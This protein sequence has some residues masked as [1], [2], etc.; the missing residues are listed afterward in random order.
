MLLRDIAYALRTL[1]KAPIFA[2]TAILTIALGI[3]ASTAIF[4]VTHA[5][6]L[7]PLPYSNPDRLVF[8]ISDLRNRNVKDSLFPT[9]ISWIFATDRRMCFRT[10]R[11][12]RPSAWS[13]PSKMAR[14]NWSAARR[15]A[16]TS[17][18]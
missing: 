7:R 3:G 4:S 1:R 14:R 6:L 5:V 15:P 8:A 9:P 18:A 10:L 13:S 11:P 17:S 12:S 16:P 2:A